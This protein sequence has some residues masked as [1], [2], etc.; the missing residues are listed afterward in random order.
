[1]VGS[2]CREL[3]GTQAE[4]CR[5]RL[6]KNMTFLPKSRRDHLTSAACPLGP[7]GVSVW[8]RPRS[9]VLVSHPSPT[10]IFKSLRPF[11]QLSN[12]ARL[13]G[14]LKA[15]F[16][17]RLRFVFILGLRVA[18]KETQWKYPFHMMLYERRHFSLKVLKRGKPR[19][20]S[21]GCRTRHGARSNECGGFSGFVWSL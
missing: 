19:N 12:M 5:S 13:A 10:L 21:V 18:G 16:M 6:W 8:G 17:Q 4:I 2:F 14:V 15:S 7:A 20:F 11:R 9:S 3:F 1:M